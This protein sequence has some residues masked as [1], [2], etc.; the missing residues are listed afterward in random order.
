MWPRQP[1]L[2]SW[3]GHVCYHWE[4]SAHN[5]GMRLASMMPFIWRCHIMIRHT[6]H[7]PSPPP[8]CPH[9][10]N[11]RR[12]QA[13]RGPETLSFSVLPSFFPAPLRP[14]RWSFRID[15]WSR[16]CA[17]VA[18]STACKAC[19]CSGLNCVEFRQMLINIAPRSHDGTPTHNLFCRREA[20]YQLGA[21]AC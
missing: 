10:L 1:R 12:A 19:L 7:T 11:F 6:T 17:C 16:A 5:S 15:R 21:G 8:T 13:P 4:S 9:R 14:S 3:W 20:P 2:D 18:R